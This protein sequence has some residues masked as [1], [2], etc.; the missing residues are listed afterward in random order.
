[1]LTQGS[2]LQNRYRILRQIGGGG[3]GVVY[4][5]EDNRLPG[6]NCAIKE[7]SPAQLAPKD[8]NWAINAFRQE[9]QMLAQ[10]S[11]ASLTAVTDFLPEGGN[12]YLVMDYVEGETLE[13][14]L[15]RTR[16]G[17]LPLDEA[18]NV[19]RQLCDVLEYL[20][21]QIP[22]VVFRDLK[23]GN[24][25]LTPQGEV[26]LIDFGIARFFKPGQTR[27][28]V[29]LGTPGY[30]APEQHGRG[31]TDTRS[32]VYSLGVLLHQMLTGYDPMATPHLLPLARSLNPGIRYEMEQ[33]IIR[34]TQLDAAARYQRVGDFRQAILSPLPPPPSPSPLAWLV[35]LGGVLGLIGLVAALVIGVALI[36]RQTPT[37]TLSTGGWVSPT[38]GLT[39]TP[40]PFPPTQALVPSPTS[41]A[42][43]SSPTVAIVSPEQ[44]IRD[45]YSAINNRQYEVTWSRL[46]D[47]FKDKFNCC[48]QDGYHDFDGYLRWWD[49]VARVDI[50]EVRIIRQSDSTATVFAELSYLLK[51]GRRV[52][53]S[54]PYIQL[55][56]DDSTCAWLFYDKGPNP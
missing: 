37:P 39:V 56:F 41:P 43:E 38:S 11:H 1:M 23:P 14:R 3:M 7:M 17:R 32:D 51:D 20:H 36:I 9:A 33:T 6:R 28:T 21:G 35:G 50:G 31:Q 15:E 54:K 53:D 30:A 4:M 18:L 27:D 44:A 52:T 2:I 47:H 46:S 19:T 12:W 49:S 45:Y 10:L 24:V 5:A 29:N 40:M 25:M 8:R 55:V 34:A 26:K 48:T 22:P 13:E 42:T 16:K